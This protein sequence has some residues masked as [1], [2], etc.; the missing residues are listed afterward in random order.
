M[1]EQFPWFLDPTEEELQRLWDEATFSFDANVLLNLYRVDKE[2]TEDY[3]KIFRALG[4][5]IFLPHEA[6]HQFFR[7]RRGV[8]RTEQ[9]S[10]SRAKEEVE[11]WVERRKVF[12]NIKNQLRGG[13]IGQI[14]ED[15]IESVFE[16]RED[17]NEE[18]EAVK[19]DLMERIENLEERFT[20]TG[21]TR[22]NAEEDEILEGLIEIFEGKTGGELNKDLDELKK[23]ARKRYDRKKPPGYEDYDG[24]EELSRGECEDFLVWQQL[25]EF[26][27]REDEDVVFITGEK[28]RDWWEKDDDHNLIRPK[29]ELL[30]EFSRETEQSFWM[31]LVKPMLNCAHERLGV[32]VKDKSVEQTDKIPENRQKYTSEGEHVSEKNIE[33]KKILRY[34][35]LRK[36][37]RQIEDKI[38]VLRQIEDGVDK[39]MDEEL[40]SNFKVWAYNTDRIIRKSREVSKAIGR[41]KADKFIDKVGVIKKSIYSSDI[42]EVKSELEGLETYLKQLSDAVRTEAEAILTSLPH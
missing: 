38:D 16:D 4:D 25:L 18:V 37:S 27:E 22:A 36:K 11:K 35:K 31:L 33:D 5:R 7:N 32:E 3:F 9:N 40:E 34:D 24:E 30:R 10:F 14:V 20:P 29:H 12:N 26:A 1:R 23:A 19:E 2:T 28:K 39:G 15:E 17:Y 6:A 21:T 41:T 8:I 42:Y 13:D